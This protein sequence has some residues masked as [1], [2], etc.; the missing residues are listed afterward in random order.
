M[1]TLKQLKLILANADPG[2]NVIT[3]IGRCGKEY[4]F[5]FDRTAGAHQRIY[6]GFSDPGAVTTMNGEV[7]DLSEGILPVGWVIRPEFVFEEAEN[8]LLATAAKLLR[9]AVL[10]LMANADMDAARATFNDEEQAEIQEILSEPVEALFAALGMSSPHERWQE[11]RRA[12][13]EGQK[14][15]LAAAPAPSEPETPKAP[16]KPRPHRKR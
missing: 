12:R 16:A 13:E 6:Q 3:V 5:I 14:Q 7:A 8:E 1:K 4:L 10:R 2:M 9:R 15:A 11:A